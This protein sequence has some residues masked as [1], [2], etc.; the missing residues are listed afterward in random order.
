M[1]ALCPRLC[2][3]SIDGRW[4]PKRRVVYAFIRSLERQL[5]ANVQ[6]K[7]TVTYQDVR[8][9]HLTLHASHTSAR[10]GTLLLLTTLVFLVLNRKEKLCWLLNRTQQGKGEIEAHHS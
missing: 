4:R 9:V 7:D 3:I 6:V 8:C 10:R 1:I 5:S 2:V